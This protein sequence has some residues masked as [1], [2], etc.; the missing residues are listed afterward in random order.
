[1]KHL[2][3]VG[4]LLSLGSTLSA[5]IILVSPTELSGTGLGSVNTVL[6]LTSPTN[7]TIETGC[8]A[9]SGAGSTTTGCGFAD[10]SVQAQFGSPSL[11]QLGIANAADLRIVLNASEPA[12]NDIRLN[13]L[14][15]SLYSGTDVFNASLSPSAGI[16]FPSTAQ[17]VGNSGFVFAL[18][19]PTLCGLVPGACPAGTDAT[20]AAAAQTFIASHG[21]V[22]NVRV[23]LGT[24]L[25]VAA[26]GTGSATGGLET[27]FVESVS[28]IGGPGGGGGGGA[29]PE[30]STFLL[31]GA[32]LAGLVSA[33]RIKRA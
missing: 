13:S 23:G 28:S 11:S 1:M 9:P 4:I 22:G 24:S 21:G 25:G 14:V 30:P 33:R 19:S 20:E 32:G 6:T 16:L 2:V 17:G 7:A 18:A 3:G 5:S 31:L 10:S 27:F 15:L 12:G 29:I 8:V 26:G